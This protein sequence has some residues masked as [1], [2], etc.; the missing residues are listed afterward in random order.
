M[1]KHAPGKVL[2]AR[3]S[4]RP[5]EEDSL[6]LQSAESLGRVI[7]SLQ[8]QMRDT[9]NLLATAATDGADALP[10]LPR[11]D[12]V[13]KNVENVFG[14]KRKSG[15]SRRSPNASRVSAK[16]RTR[17]AAATRKTAKSRARKSAKKR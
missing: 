4:D 13:I 9:S 6:L 15:G 3:K 1:A 8:R 14:N 16:K 7:G 12:A 2:P 10:E 11:F 17:G 5:A